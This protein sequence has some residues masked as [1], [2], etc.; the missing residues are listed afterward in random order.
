MLTMYNCAKGYCLY[1]LLLPIAAVDLYLVYRQ[2]LEI[3]VH[4][5][6]TVTNCTVTDAQLGT[7]YFG[8]YWN[9]WVN[10]TVPGHSI[11]YTGQLQNGNVTATYKEY[12]IFA[13]YY[14]TNHPQYLYIIRQQVTNMDVL[15]I[16]L[17]CLVTAPTVLML[18]GIL[19][20][21]GY[22]YLRRHM[23]KFMLKCK[24]AL[25]SL[26]E[27]LTTNKRE[28]EAYDLEGEVKLHTPNQS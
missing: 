4:L 27:R 9:I 21:L 8:P 19:V 20:I 22:D 23:G 26:K 24:D 13:C 17:L 25:M 18:L 10:Y 3:D 28:N 11:N 5:Y 16:V 2:S 15:G 7:D 1:I 6:N 12:N 14:A